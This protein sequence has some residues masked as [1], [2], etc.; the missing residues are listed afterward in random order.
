[1][2]TNEGYITTIDG[3]QLLYQQ[4]GSGRDTVIIPG[5]WLLDSNLLPLAAYP[6]LNPD[7]DIRWIGLMGADGYG[8]ALPLEFARAPDVLLADTLNGEPL[9]LAHGQPLRLIAPA[10]Y[11]YKSVKH[12][13]EIHLLRGRLRSVAG[14]FFE[15]PVGLVASEQRVRGLPAW[16]CRNIFRPVIPAFVNRFR[17][18][19][20]R[21]ACPRN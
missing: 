6:R 2:Q 8:S 13:T 10:H 19:I 15:H 16:L 17:K 9:S 1:M 7:P 12:I 20:E 4:T 3:L 21:N 11:A 5:A 14:L 18:A